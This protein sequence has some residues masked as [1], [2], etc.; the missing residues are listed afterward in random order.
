MELEYLVHFSFFCS[1]LAHLILTFFGFLNHKPNI[2][3]TANVFHSIV[4]PNKFHCAVPLVENSHVK[5][6]NPQEACSMNFLR[7]KDFCIEFSRNVH[8]DPIR[9]P[10]SIV[11]GQYAYIAG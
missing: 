10:V 9:D 11:C 3:V 1:S 2:L 4:L 8:R 6:T 7:D 5:Y